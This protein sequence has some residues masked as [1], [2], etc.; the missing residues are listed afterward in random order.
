MMTSIAKNVTILLVEDDPGHARLVEKNLRRAN[1]TNPIVPLGD[2]RQAVEYL[3]RE[4]PYSGDPIPA[5]LL[6]LLDLNLP[7]MDGYQVLRRMKG[8]AS[9]RRIPVIVLTTTD[10]EREIDRCYDLGC[11]VYITKP[12]DY[13]GFSEAIRKLGLFLSVV[14]IP[15][16]RT[17]NHE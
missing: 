3:F 1:L 5:N 2:G 17:N 14:A 15:K 4:G 7:V 10:D 13:E 11:N 8:N 6:V 9:T 12:V 16:E